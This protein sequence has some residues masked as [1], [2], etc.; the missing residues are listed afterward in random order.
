MNQRQE[1]WRVDPGNAIGVAIRIP[2]ECIGLAL[3]FLGASVKRSEIISYPVFYVTTGN[4]VLNGR[5]TSHKFLNVICDPP[6]WCSASP[7]LGVVAWIGV[8]RSPPN[9][10]FWRHGFKQGHAR[11]SL[12]VSSDN[13]SARVRLTANDCV[14]QLSAI[15]PPEGEAW[16]MLPNHLFGMDRDVQAQ[17]YGDEWGFRY[18]GSGKSCFKSPMERKKISRLMLGL[19]L[20]LDRIMFYRFMKTVCRI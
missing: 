18:D 5:P 10:L 15:F 11:I 9:Q 2:V 12:D 4:G 3:D 13:L 6:P 7:A 1:K 17:S 8:R 16:N 20:N 14:L 19:I